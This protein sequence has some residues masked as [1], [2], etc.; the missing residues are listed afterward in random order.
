MMHAE[1]ETDNV[2]VIGTGVLRNYELTNSQYAI[3]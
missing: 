3:K 1:V 2:K